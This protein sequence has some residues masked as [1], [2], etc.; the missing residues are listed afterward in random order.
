MPKKRVSTE[1]DDGWKWIV[2][3][4]GIGE[5]EENDSIRKSR[6]RPPKYRRRKNKMNNIVL[7][8]R[9]C[10]GTIITPQI[11]NNLI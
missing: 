8:R 3:M 6:K 7:V 5:E 4:C 9:L 11:V 2:T 10:V 1:S